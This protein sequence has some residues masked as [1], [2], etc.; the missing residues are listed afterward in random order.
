MKRPSKFQRHIGAYTADVLMIGMTA[1]AAIIVLFPILWMMLASIRPIAEILAPDPGLI[2]S[3]ITPAYFAR[4]AGKVQYRQYFLN[5]WILALLCALIS[6]SLGSLSAYGFSRFRIAGARAI[7]V[8]MTALL[9]LPPVTLI[10]PY[11]Q[12]TR[13]LGLHDTILGL[14]VVNMAFILPVTV[15]LL[16]SYFDSIPAELEE[17][18]MT[19]GCTRIKAMWRILIP[20]A[21]PGIVATATIAF[22]AAWN[23][24][25]FAV[26]LTDTPRSQ[27]LTV[28]LALF[29]GQY[30][31]DW[32]SIMALATTASLPLMIIFAFLQRWVI[33][34]MTSGAIK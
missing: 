8:G 4:L 33:Q 16:K 7:L 21:S 12:L 14:I 26:T 32:N 15:W 22:V 24:F 18:A 5:S 30:V 6:A 1:G 23:E 11:F 31:R 9:M 34:G 19:D 17:A 13:A 3:R 10:V 29:F 2:P 27:P 25:L 20:L 28:G